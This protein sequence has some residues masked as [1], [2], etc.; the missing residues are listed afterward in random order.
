MSEAIDL[1]REYSNLHTN[2]SDAV[3][4]SKAYFPLMSVILDDT[5]IRGRFFFDSD[6][7]SIERKKELQQQI[8]KGNVLRN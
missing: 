3:F 1:M 6:W 2:I 8:E 5:G 7:Y 4:H